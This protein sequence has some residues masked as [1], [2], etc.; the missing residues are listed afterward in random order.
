MRRMKQMTAT[1]RHEK[2]QILIEVL[3]ALALLGV[4]STTFIGAMYTALQT[5]RIAEEKSATLTLAKSQIEFVRNQDYSENDWEYSIS[6]TQRS[7]SLAPSWWSTPPPLLSTEY[8]GY[9]VDVTG[10]SD[11]DLDGAGGPDEGI[12]TITAIAR[13]EGVVVFTMEDYEVDR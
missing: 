11:I 3:I 9:S 13:H 5:A 6:T 2:G 12:R 8:E 10:V 7:T 4:I 1:R